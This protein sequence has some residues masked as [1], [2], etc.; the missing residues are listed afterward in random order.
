MNLTRLYKELSL[1]ASIA[2][3]RAIQV[4]EGAYNTPGTYGPEYDAARER[5]LA[6]RDREARLY[7]LMHRVGQVNKPA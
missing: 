1:A 5:Y 6:W 3:M 7:A 2:G 4:R